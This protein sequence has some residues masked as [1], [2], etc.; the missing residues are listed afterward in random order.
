MFIDKVRELEKKYPNSK[1]YPLSGIFNIKISDIN[2]DMLTIESD[3]SSVVDRYWNTSFEDTTLKIWSEWSKKEGIFVD[4]GAHTGLFTITSLKCNKKNNVLSIEPLPINFFR[5]ITNLRLNNYK[6]DRVT[7]FN[8][9]VTN[10]N[11]IVKFKTNTEWSYLSKGGKIDNNGSKVQAIS[12]D[13]IKFNNKNLQINAIKIDT[14]GEDLNVLKGGIKL[15]KKNLPKIIIETRRENAE[16]IFKFL[17]EIG[18]NKIYDYNKTLITTD[19]P[20]IFDD[21]EISKDIFCE[22]D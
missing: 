11:K 10:E 17:T 21:A 20:L 3:D 14:E 13:S 9:A 16:A 8:Y 15:I 4:V 2:F 7:L 22:Y 19:K 6:Q 5:I 12:L 1:K 18:Y